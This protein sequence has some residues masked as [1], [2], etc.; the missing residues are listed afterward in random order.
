MLSVSVTLPTRGLQGKNLEDVP[1]F[2]Q[3]KCREDRLMRVNSS[4]CD[5]L[6]A[7]VLLLGNSELLVACKV[8]GRNRQ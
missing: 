7:K 4:T 6:E 3:Q 1:E 2:F 8:L 5:G